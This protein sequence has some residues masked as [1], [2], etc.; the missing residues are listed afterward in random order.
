MEPMDA[1]LPPDTAMGTVT[2]TSTD[3]D[4]LATFYERV[5]GLT[6]LGRTD[7]EIRLG[8]VD[9]TRPL[10]TIADAPGAPDGRG[11]NGLFHLAVLVPD[12]PELGHAVRRVIDSGW[13]LTGASDH[14]VSEALYLRDPEG[15]GI[16]IYRDRPRAEWDWVDGLVDMGTVPLDLQGVVAA[17]EEPETRV[18]VPRDT[19][20]GHVHLSTSPLPAVEA[21]Y[22]DV[23][24]FDVTARYASQAS[25]LSAGGYHHHL[26]ANLW[27]GTGLVPPPD[28]VAGLRSFEIVVPDAAARDALAERAAAADALVARDD[29]GLE[30]RDPAG[31]RALVT[32]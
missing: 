31:L 24:G 9:G 13:R 8:A 27:G 18:R 29:D 21:F 19:T 22:R 11:A 30:L 7:T 1:T 2:L 26:G 17:A 3:A 10:V 32:G 5:V 6:R 12:R 15:N 16:E 25:F 14:F 20:M 4:A 28:G 23:V